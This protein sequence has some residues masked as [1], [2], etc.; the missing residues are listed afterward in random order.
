MV[1][2]MAAQRHVP[3]VDEQVATAI[4]MPAGADADAALLVIRSTKAQGLP[5]LF[6]GVHHL[7]HVVV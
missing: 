1:I 3:T 4:G 6:S 5:Y 7:E 2:K